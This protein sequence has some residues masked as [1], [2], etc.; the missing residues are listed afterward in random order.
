MGRGGE[1]AMHDR[2]GVEGRIEFGQK[3]RALGFGF[4]EGQP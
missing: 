1:E 4:Q 3:A 2:H